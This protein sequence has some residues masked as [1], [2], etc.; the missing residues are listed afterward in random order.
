MSTTSKSPRKVALVALGIGKK[1]LS[2]YSHLFSPKVYTQP[3]LFA[4]LVLKEFFKTDY[5]GVAGILGDTPGLCQ[6][7]GL[8]KVPHW[9]TIQKAPQ[10]LSGDT[11]QING[12]PFSRG[13]VA[14]LRFLG[15]NHGLLDAL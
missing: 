8:A 10:A 5:R 1:A 14:W 4:C 2:T 11:I 7:I 3:Q 6:G 13:R 12:L 15:R 9:T